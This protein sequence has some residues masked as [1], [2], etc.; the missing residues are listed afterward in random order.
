MAGVVQ[1]VATPSYDFKT[2]FQ[3]RILTGGSK[4]FNATGD[5]KGTFSISDSPAFKTTWNG[6]AAYAVGTTEIVNIS[7]CSLGFSGTQTNITYY[8]MNFV[9]L[10][11]S[12]SDGSYSEYV[13]SSQPTSLK[14][15]DTGTLGTWTHWNNTSKSVKYEI[16]VHSYVVESDTTNSV[17]FNLIDRT[18]DNN[19]QLEIT[20]QLRFRLSS[21][22]VLEWH[23]VTADFV[24]NQGR[25]VLQ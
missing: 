4:T 1:K 22:G 15:G 18:Y 3:N 23:S 13:K 2:A 7:N 21:T 19:N 9:E 10:A 25:L 24:N 8:D 11:K 12:H 5:C 14:V 20:S 16:D 6:Q 17:I